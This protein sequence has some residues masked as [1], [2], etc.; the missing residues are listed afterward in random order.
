MRDLADLFPGF[1]SHWIDVEAGRI[2]ARSGGK[3]PPLLLLHGFPQTH[4]MWHAIAPKLTETFTVVAMDL[5]GYG[6]SAVPGGEGEGALYTKRAMARDAVKVMAELGFVHFA[7]VGHDRGARVAYRLALD[8]PGRL[9]RLAL[10]DILPTVLMWDRMDATLAMQVYHWTFLAQPAPMPET[11]IQG[12]PILWLE[13][14]LASWTKDKSLRGFDKRAL[15]HYRAAFNDPDRIHATC[16]DYRAGATLDPA[17]D[18]EDLAAG[19]RLGCPTA[20]I[21]GASGIPAAGASPLAA[22]RETFAPHATGSAVDSGHFLAEE[23]P[24]GTLDA[25]LPFLRG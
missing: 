1:E 18:R 14:T 21:W 4:V 3:G 25:L 12:A 13:H 15:A 8:H 2:F 23:N 20:V 22:W 11:L 7:C 16:E 19:K 5:R 24:Q 6:W 17:N 10:L 9:S